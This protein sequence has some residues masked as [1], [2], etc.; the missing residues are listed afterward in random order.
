MDGYDPAPLLELYKNRIDSFFPQEFDRFEH[1]QGLLKQSPKERQILVDS[2]DAEEARRDGLRDGI[3]SL[4]AET[5]AVTARVAE[6]RRDL[7]AHREALAAAKSQIQQLSALRQPAH[8]DLT[9]V[10]YLVD[11]N[12]AALDARNVS[13]ILAEKLPVTL[14]QAAPAAARKP[15]VPTG[16]SV[17]ATARAASRAKQ[18]PVPHRKP[19]PSHP[20]SPAS[21]SATINSKATKVVE[22]ENRLTFETR[23]AEGVLARFDEQMA[24]LQATLAR[25]RTSSSSTLAVDKNEVEALVTDTNHVEQQ[26]YLAVTELLKLRSK[27][28]KTQREEFEELDRTRQAKAYFDAAEH[29]VATRLTE[30]V[31]AVTA[32]LHDDVARAEADFAARC[33]EADARFEA[34]VAAGEEELSEARRAKAAATV[35]RLE[36]ELE[37][38]DSKVNKLHKRFMLELEG[39][40]SDATILRQRLKR[41]MVQ[42]KRAADRRHSASVAGSHKPV[43][44]FAATYPPPRGAD[45]GVKSPSSRPRPRPSWSPGSAAASIMSDLRLQ[46]HHQQNYQHHRGGGGSS[47]EALLRDDAVNNDFDLRL[48]DLDFDLDLLHAPPPYEYS[49]GHHLPTVS[50]SPLPSPEHGKR[51]AVP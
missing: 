27:I 31:A 30:E 12:H 14:P 9:H 6:A 17:A 32:R 29:V 28:A 25:G 19:S 42:R 23:R 26:V 20:P 4:D 18:P 47:S 11:R 44:A 34:V 24:Q 46:Q 50:F 49:H 22:L 51:G 10:Q 40:D 2:L 7:E 16:A 43:A 33:V 21:S 3:A 35:R 41:A 48:L 5:A 8:R 15:A 1:Y 13:G 45:H 38:A 39:F 36:S 37:A